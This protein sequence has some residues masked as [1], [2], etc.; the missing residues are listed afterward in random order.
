MGDYARILPRDAFNEGDLLKCIGA[1]WI[2][3]DAPGDRRAGFDEEDVPVFDISQDQDDGAIEVANLT[4]RV[5]GE[6]YRLKRPLNSRSPWPLRL[7]SPDPTAD[8]EPMRVFDDVGRP[9]A[10]FA[11]FVGLRATEY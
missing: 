6:I 5:D 8:F 10:E 1:L 4:F 11:A 2:M 3:L 9:S 7:E